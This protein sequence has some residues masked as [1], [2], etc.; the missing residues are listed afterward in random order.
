MKR[1]KVTRIP[2][3]IAD[4]FAPDVVE[5][6]ELDTNLPSNPIL[7]TLDRII[8]AKR[9]AQPANGDRAFR[10]AQI[11]T[12][13]FSKVCDTKEDFVTDLLADVRHY[14]D[15]NQ[16]CFGDQDRRAHQHYLAEKEEA[17]QEG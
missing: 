1:R 11:E 10:I 15:A 12:E 16:L 9:D 8:T 14:C 7:K 17:K 2:H 13:Y 4:A 3:P 6:H 5:R